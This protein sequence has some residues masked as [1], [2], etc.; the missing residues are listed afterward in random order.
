M[1][2]I[3]DQVGAIIEPTR[4]APGDLNVEITATK[5]ALPVTMSLCSAIAEAAGGV[6]RPQAS[7]KLM[8]LLR[9][10]SSMSCR[11]SCCEV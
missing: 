3:L 1:N 2:A 11:S 7:S 4:A 10:P 5:R 8:L 9:N 6:H